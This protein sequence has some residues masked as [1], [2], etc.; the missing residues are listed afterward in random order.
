MEE[1]LSPRRERG[2]NRNTLQLFGL[3]FMVLGTLGSAVQL[4]YLNAAAAADGEL[5]ATAESMNAATMAIVFLAVQAMAVPI[6]AVLTLDGF[7]KTASVKKY[8][9]RLLALAAASEVPY[10]LA[11]TGQLWEQ[12]SHNPVLGLVVAVV[13]L[14]LMRAYPGADVKGIAVKVFGLIAGCLWCGI[15]Q[16]EY[17]VQLVLLV[18]VLWIFRTRHTIA[19]FAGTA[20]ALVCTVGDPL[21]LFAPF[22]FLLTHFYNG[23]QKETKRIVRY[24]LYPA[25]LI[26]IAALAAA[27]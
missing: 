15:F 26:V 10:H 7:Q 16:V 17:G 20:I 12:T 4:R 8:L 1:R 11:R 5:L 25:M 3:M 21:F 2:L 13:M 22:G 23:T 9:L 6:F 27:A 19:Y 18:F 14:Y 24:G